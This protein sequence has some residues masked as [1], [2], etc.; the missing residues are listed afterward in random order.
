MPTLKEI[1]NGRAGPLW[2]ILCCPLV[3]TVGLLLKSIRFY[4]IPCSTVLCQRLMVG[5]LWRY[6]C[7]CFRWP[8]EDDEFFG[9]KALGDH[10]MND[11]DKPTGEQMQKDTDWVRAQDLDSFAGKRPQL[12]EGEIEPNDLCQGAVGDCWLVA[13]FACASEFPDMIR[14]MFLTKE[15]NPRG[16]YKVRIYDPQAERWVVIK[17]DDR[18]PCEKGTKTPRF[19]KPQGN[20][21]WAILLEKAYAKFAGSYARLD[22]GF[23]LWGWLSMTGDNVFQLSVENDGKWAREDMVAMQDK[24]DPADKR[25]CGFRSTKEKYTSDQIWTLLKKYDKQKAL[26]SASIGK[27]EYGKNDGPSGEQM[28]EKQG[29]VAG[30]AYSVIQARSVT[31]HSS[32]GVPKPGG[33]SFN[34]LKLRN[35]WGTYEW[36]GNWSDKSALWK[37]YPSIAKQLNFVDEDDGC[38]WMEYDDFRKVYTRINI[39][40]RDTSRDASLNVNEDRGWYGILFC[41]FICG[42]ANF[43]CLCKGLRNLY[44]SHASTDETLDAKE[45]CCFIC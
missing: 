6:V 30:H 26:I 16:I 36:K 34:L 25:A 32:F 28:M 10:S 38:F 19:M 20:E 41:G 29:L 21:L 17:V 40:D 8:Y 2:N 15:Y 14:H 35:P 31:E 44:C 22:G 23:V 18:I 13:A 43:W 1:N 42:C 7:C 5:C 11:P 4:L 39:C 27:V 33:K 37:K 24:D 9:A 3:G 45:K 12:F